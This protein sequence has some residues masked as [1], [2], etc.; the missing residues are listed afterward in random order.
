M[1][2]KKIKTYHFDNLN[3]RIQKGIIIYEMSGHSPLT[4]YPLVYIVYIVI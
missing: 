2:F 1:F 3:L 4:E